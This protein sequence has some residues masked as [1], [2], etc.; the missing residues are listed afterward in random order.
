MCV[1]V[2][3]CAHVGGY[4]RVVVP[5][6]CVCVQRE[7]SNVTYSI[8]DFN[9]IKDEHTLGYWLWFAFT[10]NLQAV[11]LIISPLLTQVFI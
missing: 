8:S 2:C 4:V 11:L 9:F 3:V 10:F 5:Y 6:E 1:C 7:E